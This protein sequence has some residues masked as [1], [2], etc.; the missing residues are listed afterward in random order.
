MLRLLVGSESPVALGEVGGDRQRSP[1]QLVDEEAITSG[2]LFGE[3]GHVIGQ[4]HGLLADLELLEHEGHRQ[5]Q[6]EQ[7]SS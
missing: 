6:S 5:A 2:E 1:V 3:S 4:L 7:E